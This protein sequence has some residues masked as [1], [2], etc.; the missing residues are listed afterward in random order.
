MLFVDG[1]HESGSW[2]QHLVDED[3]NGLLG[4]EL[5]SLADDVD[6]LAYGEIC[7]DEVLLLV[8]GRDVRLFDLLAND[9][10]ARRSVAIH[11]KGRKSST[12]VQ[13]TN[14]RLP[15]CGQSTL[16]GSARP[17]PCASRRGARP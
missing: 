6:E 7:W 5:D 12:T 2:R 1:A 3:E 15:E 16:S 13:K 17:P 14:G 8:D 11:Q 4:R 10:G 9:L